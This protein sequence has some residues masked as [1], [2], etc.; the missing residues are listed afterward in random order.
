MSVSR[1]SYVNNERYISVEWLIQVTNDVRREATEL[2]EEMKLLTTQQDTLFDNQNNSTRE[3]S[4]LQSEV[5][6][7][8]ARYSQLKIQTRA[9]SV[10]STSNLNSPLRMD[11][12]S[13][14]V[15]SEEGVIE[16]ATISRFQ[17]SIDDLL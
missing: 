11:V 16:D 6:D 13:R 12:R 2:L 8:K 15:P 10:S 1:R 14:L 17:H 9:S 5:R 4:R 7:W 3:I